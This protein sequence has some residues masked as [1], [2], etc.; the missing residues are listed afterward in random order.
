MPGPCPS[1]KAKG[2]AGSKPTARGSAG[3][4]VR[5]SAVGR[6]SAHSLPLTCLPCR[7]VVRKCISET[8]PGKVL[9]KENLSSAV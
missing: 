1:S 8:S 4:R 6:L 9:G 5:T 2:L 3:V 7:E